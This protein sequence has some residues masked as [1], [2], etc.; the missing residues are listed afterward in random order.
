MK[1]LG[2]DLG[3]GSV[4]WAV[5]S[6]DDNKNPKEI[7]GMGSRIVSLTSDESNNFSK[8]SGETVCAQ[9]TQ[10]R[11]A[12]KILDRYQARRKCLADLLKALDMYD[13]G[14]YIGKSPME[15]WQLRADAATFGCR[16]TL[17]EIGNVLRHINQKRGYRHSKADMSDSKL[18]DFVKNVNSRWKELQESGETPGQYS[19]RM[20]KASEIQAKDGKKVYSYRIKDKQDRVLPRQAYE[21]E[22]D[23]I[24]SNQAQ[25]WPDVLTPYNINRIK[26]VIFYQRPLKSCKHLVS[27][28]EF[29]ATEYQTENG[30]K[31]IGGPKVAP[32]TA[33]LAQLCRIYEAVN[34]L[35]LINPKNKR[36]EKRIKGQIALMDQDVESMPKDIRLMQYNYRF[37]SEERQR[38]VDFLRTH[39]KM[40]ETDLLKILG[41]K[42]AD[43]FKVD[44]NILRGIPG[45]TTYCGLRK[46][47]ATVTNADDLLIFEI[48]LEDTG[49]IDVDTGEMIQIVSPSYEQQPL[50][51]LWHLV[52]SCQTR[53]ELAKNLSFK[54]GIE[55][56]SVV[57][58]LFALNF[59]SKGF[60]NKSAKFMRKIIPFLMAGDHYSDAAMAVGVN[61][62]DSLTKEENQKRQLETSLRSLKKG[63]LRQPTVEKILNQMINIVN[64]VMQKWGPMDEIRIELARELKQNKDRRSEATKNLVK[65][66]KENGQIALKLVEYGLPASRKNIQKYRLHE[67]SG[68]TCIYCGQPVGLVEFVGGHGGEVEHIIPRSLLFDDSYSNKACSC[69]KCNQEKG[70]KTG[71]DFMASKGEEELAVYVN[72][73]TE[74]YKSGKISRTKRDRLLCEGTKIPEDFIERD[75]RQ[76]QYIA[77]KAREI[78]RTVCY[79][80]SASSGSVT[81]FFRHVW[82]YDKILHDLNLDR[83]AKADLVQRVEYEHKRQK[84]EELR[85]EGWTKRYDHRHHAVDALVIALTRQGY[86]QRL[87]NLNKE[88]DAMFREIPGIIEAGRQRFHLL[89][90]WAAT[91]PHFAVKTV[92]DYVNTIA[93][94]FKPGKKLSTPGKRY[95]YRSGKR[96]E[97]QRGLRIPR[98]SLHQETIYG[99]IKLPSGPKKLKDAFERPD[100]IVNPELREEILHRLK[101]NSNDPAEALRS[102]KKNP[103]LWGRY[104][105]VVSTIECFREEFVRRVN[106][107][108]IE[109]K[110]LD[111]VLDFA[112]REAIRARYAECG[113]HFK[114]YQQSLSSTPITIGHSPVRPVWTVRCATGLKAD[115]MV[116]A[117]KSDLNIPIGYAKSANNH[118]VCFYISPDGQVKT[119]ISSFW[120]CMKRQ[121]YGLP[122]II[123]N[124]RET[125]DIVLRLPE[126]PDT[127]EITESLPSPDWTFLYSLQM[128]EMVILGLSE[129]QLSDARSTNDRQT[130]TQHLYRV[131]KLSDGE[132]VFR[133]HTCVNSDKNQ[134]DNAMGMF[135]RLC[136]FD[137]IKE[138]NLSKVY[139]NCLGEITF[140]DD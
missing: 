50:N 98:G 23:T 99:K 88:R 44:G 24:L 112:I 82:G 32:R 43:G 22:V 4:G 85:I 66:E 120:I 31:V 51:R 19:A 29:E 125:A 117:R 8:G 102:I 1:I 128:N 58:A 15:V 131:Q 41:L 18:T 49:H 70:Q 100:L 83:Y 104:K 56:E 16:L 64:A 84:H 11:T 138:K 7:L 20:L 106:V 77:K 80:V 121:K 63:D 69:R 2:L 75:L 114:R 105:K 52:Y 27:I 46:A 108:D 124:P 61:H 65:R 111:K 3:V 116:A 38:I 133:L 35:V 119:M 134:N 123:S 6:T 76:S 10:M 34:N 103:I 9:R 55:D 89:E 129:E 72:R 67:E 136:S 91:R 60:S 94:S 81:D 42:K 139:V 92:A 17:K 122:V 26:S 79:E 115:K 118:H 47:L 68:F 90:E 78:L 40:T 37:T 14:Y 39:D 86:I 36:L 45:D 132:Y 130:L 33:P 127:E 101:L 59:P 5:I 126:N 21:A 96:K 135:Y 13:E 140:K 73:V 12:R 110:N 87:S 28:C 30:R 95:I 62:S 48:Q 25:Y 113:N 53:K 109:L 97:A 57:D 93:V 74:L 107:S 54:Y 137:A 71:F